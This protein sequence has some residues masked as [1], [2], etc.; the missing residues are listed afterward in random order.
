LPKKTGLEG[1]DPCVHSAGELD[2]QNVSSD[3]DED[4]DDDGV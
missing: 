3:D 4:D 2:V 1:S